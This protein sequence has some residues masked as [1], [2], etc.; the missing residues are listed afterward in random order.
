MEARFLREPGDLAC[1][2]M[3]ALQGANVV[4][5]DTRCASNNSSSLFAFLKV[6]NPDNEFNEPSFIISVKTASGAQIEPIDSLQNLFD[7]QRTCEVVSSIKKQKNTSSKLT[8]YPNPSNE[9]ITVSL[10]EK[11]TDGN[12]KIFNTLGIFV[13]DLGEMK[14]NNTSTFDISSL[15]KGVYF[16][17][18][19]NQEM[20]ISQKI[21]IQ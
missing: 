16:L 5:A 2:L 8:I 13:Q 9:T 19:S 12:L 15:A 6:A 17:E 11:H 21:F 18:F 1:K 20:K 4:G 14:S 7:A 3:A 10:T